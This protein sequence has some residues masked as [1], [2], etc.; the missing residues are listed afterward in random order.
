MPQEDQRT[1]ELK[2][3]KEAERDEIQFADFRASDRLHG[4]SHS[5]NTEYDQTTGDDPEIDVN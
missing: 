2:H 3:A 1:S 5:V 4:S